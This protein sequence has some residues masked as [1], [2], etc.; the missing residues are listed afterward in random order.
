M[1]LRRKQASGKSSGQGDSAPFAPGGSRPCRTFSRTKKDLSDP[2]SD[3]SGYPEYIRRSAPVQAEK[4]RCGSSPRSGPD[5]WD[6]W[7]GRSPP[8][9]GYRFRHRTRCRRSRKGWLP[10]PHASGPVFYARLRSGRLS[11][12]RPP[13]FRPA[14][15]QPARA[16]A[17]AGNAAVMSDAAHPLR[18][19]EAAVPQIRLRSAPRARQFPPSQ[20]A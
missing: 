7:S 20:P 1:L 16:A 18:L 3:R 2:H 14:V 13:A 4:S 5:G 8:W 11:G 17:V 10:A 9:I 19:P 12:A 6:R 15:P